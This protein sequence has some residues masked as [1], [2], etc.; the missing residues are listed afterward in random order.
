MK[1]FLI[2]LL[3]LALAASV[4][5]P[6]AAA[7]PAAP[8]APAAS[9]PDVVV[10]EPAANV[11]LDR[12]MKRLR[13]TSRSFRKAVRRELVDLWRWTDYRKECRHAPLVSVREFRRSGFAYVDE[14]VFGPGTCAGGGNWQFF[15]RRGGKWRTPRALGGQESPQCRTLAR[16]GIP[17]MT[18]AEECYS[19]GGDIL[20]Y[21]PGGVPAIDWNADSVQAGE[22]FC[23]TYLQG[24]A[25][26][27]VYASGLECGAVSS[28]TEW[29]STHE[30][31]GGWLTCEG[32]QNGLTGCSAG[33]VSTIGRSTSRPYLRAVAPGGFPSPTT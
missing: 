14:G 22:R 31:P 17:R 15:V 6:P 1:A 8:A 20:N 21:F 27:H 9:R 30:Q 28:L 7:A 32:F 16:F 25:S 2:A 12:G 33:E 26:R 5:G 13:A 19:D 10:F 23:G 29:W 18:G 11:H 4:A 3:G 24:S